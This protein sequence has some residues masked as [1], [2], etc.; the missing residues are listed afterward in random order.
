M[1]PPTYLAIK[2]HHPRDDH[3]SF[4]EG[5]HIYTVLGNRGGYTSVTTWN[6][7]HFSHFDADDILDKMFAGKNMNDPKYKY[8]G[9]TREEIKKMWNIKRDIASGSGTKMHY[10]IE[11]FMNQEMVDE[12][13]QPIP[14]THDFLYQL[15]QQELEEG[16][17]QAND[18]VEWNYFIDFVRDHPEFKPYRTEWFVYDEELKLAGSI[19]MVY[20]NPDGSLMIYD[21]KRSKEIKYEDMFQKTATT[22]CIQHIPDT[23]FW[24]YSLQL[25]TYKAILE[26]NYGKKITDLFLVILHPDH[27]EKTYELIRCADLTKEITA[28]FHHR[29]MELANDR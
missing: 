24:H 14:T 9:M 21:W 8:Y 6:H 1:N 2:N 20:E 11:C 18:S 27:P 26:K 17:P 25:N 13:I 10:D 3:I 22:E 4:E 29:K 5:P 28:L 7:S 19:D 23:N 15:Y 16:V 12:K